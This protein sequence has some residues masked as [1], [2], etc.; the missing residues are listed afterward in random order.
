MT[1]SNSINVGSASKQNLPIKNIVI[2]GADVIGWSAAVAL[3]R[4][5]G[6]QNV[7][8][9][10]LD[11]KSDHAAPNKS[12]HASEHIFDFHRLLGIQDKNLLMHGHMK[13]NLGAKF[14]AFNRENQAAG[15]FVLGCDRAM[16]SFCS[17]ELHQVLAWLG[18]NDPEKYSISCAAINS[19][20]LAIPTKQ[21]GTMSASFSPSVNLDGDA[22]LQFMQG[23]AKHLAIKIVQADIK[24]LEQDPENG[25][26]T[27]ITL[28]SG[29]ILD[30]DLLLDN[31][32]LNPALQ[33]LSCQRDYINCGEYLPFD[34]VLSGFEP[35]QTAASPFQQFYGVE[36]GWIEITTHS[37]L[38]NIT[39]HY[40]SQ[41]FQDEAAKQVILSHIPNVQGVSLTRKIARYLTKPLDKNCLTIGQAAGY[42]GTSPISSL[43]LMQRTLSKL[44]ELFPSKL[45]LPQ[46][47]AELN[48]RILKDYQEALHYTALMIPFSEQVQENAEMQRYSWH[49]SIDQL[50]PELKHKVELFQS[51][52]RIGSELN[53]LISRDAW[54]NLLKHKVKNRHAYEPVLHALDKHK[55]AQFIEQLGLQIEQS[56]SRY[57]PYS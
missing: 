44:L 35:T 38:R 25:F 20:L 31:S 55:A 27:Q 21:T 29:Q 17:I 22:Y 37:N 28:S 3:A 30:V 42:L 53:P 48:K 23:A 7:N 49:L 43:V 11:T 54:L 12:L 2:V 50:P 16:P 6:G 47:T 15:D 56:I 5:L 19:N 1:K 39:L 9:T 57:R 32:Q 24:D 26:V 34:S 45:C 8:I 13:L 41:L 10:I 36:G 40:S 18:L 46:N 4:G 52:G 14:H 33:V 51:S